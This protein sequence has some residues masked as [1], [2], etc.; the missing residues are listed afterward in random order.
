MSQI[1]RGVFVSTKMFQLSYI[2]INLDNF[3]F[4]GLVTLLDGTLDSK[5]SL[6]QVTNDLSAGT[7]TNDYK[8]SNS[9]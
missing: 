2:I 1:H 5:N 9:Y 8:Y 3:L 4:P 7:S 6:E